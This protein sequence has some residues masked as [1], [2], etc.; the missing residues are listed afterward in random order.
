[1]RELE[2]RRG[3]GGNAVQRDKAGIKEKRASKERERR[4]DVRRREYT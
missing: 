3:D 1:M 4:S 2:R